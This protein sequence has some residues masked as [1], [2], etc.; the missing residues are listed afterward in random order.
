MKAVRLPVSIFISIVI[1]SLLFNNLNAGTVSK[2]SNIFTLDTRTVENP[3]VDGWQILTYKGDTYNEDLVIDNQGKVWCFYFRSPGANQPIYLKIFKSDGYVYKS[4]QIVGFSSDFTE[5]KYNSI[6]AAEN[7]STGDIWVAIQGKQGGYFIIFDSTGTVRQDSTVLDKAAFSPKIA[8]GKNGK[9]WFSW[10]TQYNGGAESQGKIASYFANGKKYL[11]AQDIGRHTYIFNTDI[12]VDDSNRIW[13]VFEVNEGGDYSTKY[14]IY[15]SNLTI[16]NNKDGNIIS[17]NVAPVNPQRQIFSDVINHKI[18]ILEKDTLITQQQLHLFALNGSEIVNIENVGDCSFT[19]NNQN[20]LEVIRFNQLDLQ[21]KIYESNL[22]YPTTGFYYASQVKFDSTFQFVRNGIA[23]NHNYPAL[24]VYVVQL[25]ANLTKLKFEQVS[26]AAPEIAIKS[27]QF[28]T[29]KI[30]PNYIKRRNVKVQNNGGAILTVHNIIPNDPHFS[31]SET[32]FNVLPGQSRNI[33][34][35]F[36]PTTT[37]SIVDFILFLSNDPINDSLKVTVS[38]KGYQPTNPIIRITV[39]SLLFASTVLGRTDKKYFSIVNDDNYEPLRIYSI[40]SSNQQ[41]TTPDSSGFTLQPKDSKIITVNFT[42]NVVGEIIGV[43][44]I[45]SNDT[46]NP[47]LQLRMRGTGIRVGAPKIVVTPDSLNFGEVAYGYQKSLYIEIENQGASELDIFNITAADSQ[48]TANMTDFTIPAYSKYYLLI[49]YQVKRYGEADSYITIH[50]SDP[51]KPEYVVPVYGSGREVRPA[52]IELSHEQLNFGI[53]PVGNTKTTYF[54]ISNLGEEPLQV[55][56]ITSDNERYTVYQNS[57]TVNPGY[58]RAVAVVFSPDEPDTINGRLTITCN[59]AANDTMYLYLTGSGRNLT[60]PKLELSTERIDFG[61]VATTQSLTRNFTVHNNGEQL[62]QVSS[63][64]IEGN[65]LSYSVYPSSLTITQGQYRSVYVTFAPQY[66]GQINGTVKLTSNEPATH[67]VSLN[68]MGRDPLPQNI[69]ISHSSLTFDSVAVSQSKSLYIMIKNNGERELTVQSVTTTNASFAANMNNFKLNPGQYQYILITFSPTT[70]GPYQD[71]LTIQSDDPDSPQTYVS[72]FG[73][74]RLLRDQNIQLSAESLGFG[75]IAISQQREQGL[76]IYNTGEKELSIYS[77]TNNHSAFSVEPRNFA[78]SPQSYRHVSVTFKPES[79]I[80]YLDELKI[81]NNDPDRP[82]VEVPLSGRGRELRN[83]KI[84]VFPASLDFGTIGIGLR[85]TQNLQIR[86]DGEVVLN[87]ESIQTNSSY[88]QISSETNFSLNPGLSNYIQITFQPDSVGKFEAN[89][90]ITSDDPDSSVYQLPL[91]GY[92]RQ[93][94]DPNITFYPG[95]INFEDVAVGRSKDI[96]LYIGN[97]GEKDLNINS[98]VTTNDQFVINRT[99]QTIQPGNN[100]MI[101]ITFQP[102][103]MDTVDAE[104]IVVSNDPDSSVSTVPLRGIGRALKEPQMVVSQE[105]LNF[106]EVLLGES[107]SRNLLIQNTGDLTLLLFGIASQDSHFVVHIDSAQ[108][109]GGQSYYIA[110]TFSPSDTLEIQTT[111]EL[112]SNDP[113]NYIRYI[114][115]RGK[116]RRQTQQIAVSPSYFDFNEVLI[117]SAATQYL[118]IGNSGERS[119]TILNILSNNPHFRPQTTNFSLGMG[120]YKQVSVVFSPDSVKAFSGKL[121]IV[122][123]DPVADSLVI[124]LAGTGRDYFDQE[125]VVSPDSLHFNQV[126]LN[127]RKTLSIRIDNLGEKMLEILQITSSNPVFSTNL[128]SLQIAPQSWQTVNVSFIPISPISYSDTLKIISNDPKNDTVMVYLN[129]IGREPL[130]QKIAISDTILNF[131]EVPTDRSKSKT[132]RISN[133]G[134]RTLEISQIAVSD[135]QFHINKQWLILNPGETHDL[136]VTFSPDASGL[137]SAILTIQSNDPDT[138]ELKIS[139]T[140]TGVIYNGPNISIRPTYL[141][142]GNTMVGVTKK[143]SL[144]IRNSSR[145]DTLIVSS[146][147][148]AHEAF[149]IS[150]TTLSVLPLDSAAVQVAF[151][152]YYEGDQS[153]QVTINSNDQ[154]QLTLDFWI[155]GKGIM[156]NVGQNVLANLGWKDDGYTPVGD[157]FSPNPHTDSLLSDA[158]NRAWF[159]KDITLFEPPTTASMNICF[160][161]ELQLFVNGSLILADTAYQPLHWNTT[162]FN[163]KPYLKLGRNRISI[164]VW[165]KTYQGGFDCELIVNGEP[166]IKR[167]DQNWIHPDAT[168]WYFGGM[169]EYPVPPSDSPFNRYWFHRDYGLAGVDTLVANWVFEPTGSDTLYDNS[170][171]GQMAILH[172]VTWVPGIIGQAMQFS[173]Q[174][175]SYAELQA[176]LNYIPQFIELWFN[177]YAARQHTQNIISNKGTASYGHGMFIDQNMKLGVYY[178]DGE[179]ITNFTV[180]PNTWYYVSTQYKHDKILVYINNILV[181]STSYVQGNPVGSNIC[182]LAGNPS[183]QDNTSFFGAIDEFAIRSTDTRPTLMQQVARIS[184]VPPQT[185]TKNQDVQLSF[186]IFPNQFKILSGAFEYTWGGSNR[187][188]VKNLTS[189]DSIFN[190]PLLITIPSDSI[191]VRGLKYRTWLQTDYGVV[192]YPDYSQNEGDY[193]W[194]EVTTANETSAVA[195]PEKIHRMIS[196]PYVLD[197]SSISEVL[198]DNLGEQNDYTWRL[199]DW[200]QHDTNYI[201][202]DDSNWYYNSGFTRGKAYWLITSQPKTFDAGSGHSPENVSYRINL[203]PGWNMIG[204]PFPYPVNWNDVQKTTTSISEPIFRSTSDS[205]GWIYNVE[206]LNPWE[207]YFVWNGD[208]SDRSLIVVPQEAAISPLKKVNTLADK[209]LTTYPDVA[210]LISAGVRCGKFVDGDNL[211][212]AAKNAAEEYDQYDLQEAP[213]IGDYVSLWIDN[214]NWNRA[215]GAYTVDFK[216]EGAEGY[217]WNIVLDYSIQ[218]PQD[219]LKIKFKQLKNLPESWLMYLFD[220]SEGIAINL[221]DQSEISSHV[222][223]GKSVR[224]LYKFVIGTEAFIMQNSDDIPLV[225]LEFELFQNYPNPFNAATTFMFN[226]PKRMHISLKIYNILGQ[227]VKTIVDEEVRGGHHTIYWD[228]TNDQGNLISTG[229]YI[230]RLQTKN[231]VA[232][233]KMLLIK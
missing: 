177:C 115:L 12:A 111:L 192:M 166:K 21:N 33:T 92:G 157:I 140:G 123:D 108:V 70:V 168:W 121:V 64:A 213:V 69:Y 164:R 76:T 59:D 224:K 46:T 66:V 16:Y 55:Y 179:F 74:G 215:K 18:W 116:G 29:T 220:Q 176:N 118:W 162:N 153:V 178:Y 167:G 223:A 85:T 4:E 137:M 15:N 189:P 51:E 100:E 150:K 141:N 130:P 36:Q 156:E 43:L 103:L 83:Q 94:L 77:I 72:L 112:R 233:K 154:Y 119:L 107:V 79:L 45:S 228:G 217:A 196:I 2:L 170:P 175:N 204:N 205:I 198:Q 122:S 91:T 214:R 169:S 101:I 61:Q 1:I 218:K 31:V 126:A 147:Y 62:L 207:G 231:K 125:I 75:E 225:P 212:G 226:L 160:A 30:S 37:D 172:N 6:R 71:R 52:S 28:D 149:S 120:E 88:F 19:R 142:F 58:P 34:V 32:A 151:H 98:I 17:N 87:V 185:A 38:G 54:W 27:I 80:T 152:P 86:N 105:E 229:L 146:L 135:S 10:Q 131:G 57:F 173:G 65:N 201:A 174:I 191:T 7:D 48:Y 203:E 35:G 110:V 96:Q 53:V 14:S 144:W 97:N 40:R 82:I 193:S 180:N 8:Q 81:V 22:Y 67:T 145:S 129:G 128:T 93:L 41:F 163:V 24:K 188:Q 56:N 158:P 171:N 190:S 138:P 102:N 5:Q 219:L 155:S 127:N 26:T 39:D 68:G 209:Y 89:L 109:E 199:F 221:K 3:P 73:F 232:V 132:L 114:P 50:N 78:V 9:M 165:N 197:N 60:P 148:F 159:I 222:V 106:G 184:I 139:L 11:A 187:Y 42:P 63:I 161:E 200:V 84:A 113:N 124:P 134:E 202:Y 181:D 182:F 216:A 13:T 20:F 194:I 186:N 90:I 208:S 104:L 44:T 136:T 230:M 117:N 25:E 47:N 210:V 206:T 49:T 99:L 143:L 183:V 23:Y 133:Q 211:F 227:Q 195:L 95:S